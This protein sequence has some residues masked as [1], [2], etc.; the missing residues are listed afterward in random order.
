MSVSGKIGYVYICKMKFNFGPAH[1]FFT[2]SDVLLKT[3]PP[4]L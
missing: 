3:D 2:R 1:C 4:E